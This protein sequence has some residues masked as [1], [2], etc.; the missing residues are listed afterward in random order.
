MSV[1]AALARPVFPTPRGRHAKPR[2]AWPRVAGRAVV[3]ITAPACGLAIGGFGWLPLLL[4]VLVA[5]IAVVANV[6]TASR[7]IDAIFAE[8]LPDPPKTP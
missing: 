1:H 3:L 8:E 4:V 6:R 7:K 5:G 2:P